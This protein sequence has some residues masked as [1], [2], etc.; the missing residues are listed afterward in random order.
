M[1]KNIFL[2]IL[3][4]FLVPVFVFAQTGDIQG[5][6]IDKSSGEGIAGANVMIKG[7]TL[8]AAS[9]ADGNFL[10][11]NVPAG[12]HSVTASV[13]GYEEMTKV[14]NV[15]KGIT[16]KVNFELVTTTL[17]MSALEVLASRATRE[18]PVAYSNIEK[19]AMT[20]RLGSRD[21]PLVMNTTPS[22][23]ATA[24]GG[25]AGDARVNVRGF[26]QRNVAIMINGVPVNDME[27]AWVY[28]SNWD[29]VGDATSS[30]QMQRGLSAVNLATPSIGGTMNII[31][32]PA[33]HKRGGMFK[34]EIGAWGFLKTTLSYS[35]GLIGDKLAV[36]GSVVRKTGD[37][38]V[39]ATWT[40]AWAYY[41]GASYA[42]NKNNRFELYAVGAPQRHGQNLYKQNIATYSKSYAKDVFDKSVLNL[43][44]DTSGIADVFE[45]FS[46]IVGREFNQNWQEVDKNYDGKQYWAM[47]SK[48][49]NSDRHAKDFLNSRENYFHKPQINLNW[50]LNLNDKMRLSSIFYFSGGHGGGT[51]TYGSVKKKSIVPDGIKYVN[52]PW[53][54]DWNAEIAENS[55]NIDSAYSTTLNRSTGILRN[56]CNNQWTI[57][58]IS[59]FN[60]DFSD[61]LKFIAGIDWRTAEINHF[62]EVRDLLGGDYFVY[63][64]NAFDTEDNYMKGLGDKIAYYFTNTVDWLGF[65]GQAEYSAGPLTAYG[66]AGYSTIAYT[67]TNHFKKDENG[68]ELYAETDPISGTQFKGGASYKITE[69]LGFFGN[70]GIVSKVPIF[71][72]VI[73]D[74]A[75]VKN[76]D[77]VNETFNS[78]EAGTFYNGLNGML[79]FTANYYNTKWNDR[80]YT[81]GIVKESDEEGLISL[82]GVD[83]NHSGVEMEVAFQPMS[84]LRLNGAASFG[85]WHYTDDVEGT[86]RPDFGAQVFDTLHFYIKDLKVGDAPQTQIAF[87]ASVFPIKGLMAQLVVKSYANHYADF[88]PFSRTDPDD[89]E[90]SW[91]TPNYTIMDLHTTYYLP[92]NLHGVRLQAFAHL[93]N[94]L[95][96]EYIQDAVDNSSYNS[97]TGDGKNHKA[98]DAEVFFGI[99]RSFNVGLN[100]YF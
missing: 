56:S 79:N 63:T 35:S 6:V 57:G 55:N 19:E 72:D 93:F 85:N 24:A 75:G 47:Y 91:K 34:Q 92:I 26:N 18:T 9:D 88:S 45:A 36:N 39:D 29:G 61:N 7:T 13:I 100:V 42:L 53:V 99:P 97:F 83:A 95:D 84:L 94:L 4:L 38:F 40:D 8:G 68:D 78:F 82:K 11:N 12:V 28:W 33:A 23:Y 67:Y 50:Y 51:G 70:F 81:V 66:M 44:S 21:I 74:Y 27:N 20:L 16:A 41:L 15:I 87:G 86:Y 32:D 43:D 49:K 73:D 89:R 54:Y 1:R 58:V 80:S 48:H 14:V 2:L 10:I 69:G 60:Y 52:N 64:G 37:G 22:V 25:G 76:E 90:E 17:E 96:T 59:K 3:A 5:R 65:F 98:D 30:I 77:P 46:D 71:D 31:T 62:R